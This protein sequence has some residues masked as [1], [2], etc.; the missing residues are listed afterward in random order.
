LAFVVSFGSSLDACM[1]SKLIKCYILR[2]SV[3]Y[4]SCKI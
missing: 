4:F 1:L 2:F 3:K